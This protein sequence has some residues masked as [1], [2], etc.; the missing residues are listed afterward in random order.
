MKKNVQLASC[1]PDG[2]GQEVIKVLQIFIKPQ[3][4]FVS[5]YCGNC[6]KQVVQIKLALFFALFDRKG[7][8]KPCTLLVDVPVRDVLR[9]FNRSISNFFKLYR[10]LADSWMLLDN[11]GVIPILIAEMK[12]SKVRIVDE[13]SYNNIIKGISGI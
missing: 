2:F 1:E 10:P 13:S 5:I 8:I 9:R 3:R 12:N 4:F 11:A 6:Q 7:Q